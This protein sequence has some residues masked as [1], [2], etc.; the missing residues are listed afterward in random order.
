MSAR[1]IAVI[2][3]G[4]GCRPQID[5]DTG[6]RQS[7]IDA[8]E[9]QAVL[10][11]DGSLSVSETVTFA[12]DDG[13]TIELPG[14]VDAAGGTPTVTSPT[15]D[16]APVAVESGTFADPQL[17]IAKKQ[18]VVAFALT[19][20]VT[21]YSDIAV[22]D[23]TVLASPDGASRNDPDVRVTGTI[24]LPAPVDA[25]SVDA[26][27]Y[28]GREREIAVQATTVTFSSRAPVWTD[29]EV[30]L[31]IPEGLVPFVPAT[32]IPWADNFR[33]QA[34]TRESAARLTER[35]LRGVEL[36]LDAAEWL[37]FGLAVGIPGIFWVR[38]LLHAVAV[39]IRRRREVA[40]VP[41]HV[42]EPP[43]ADDPAVVSVLVGE[44]KPEKE[45]VAGTMLKLAQRKAI[46]IDEYGPD[47][48]VVKVPLT[49]MGTNGT[50]RIVLAALRSE[51]SDEG[52]IEGP[53]V[54]RKGAPWWRGYKRDAIH[55]AAGSGYVTRVLRLLDV[56]GALTTTAVGFCI[57]FFTRPWVF[58][59]ALP[60]AIVLS[61]VAS[62][63]AGWALTD[64]GRR[65]RALWRSFGRYI[66][67][68]GEL[69]NVGPAGV[70]IWGPYITYG[71]VLDEADDTA[72]VLSP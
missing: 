49:E 10:D 50:E 1:L 28:A 43:T 9:I 5:F 41:E 45:A 38:V 54:W 30:Q 24:T 55:A 27:N 71:V 21:R 64:K 2:V 60:A 33:A 57:Y 22:V 16:G 40:D 3:V 72:R 20:V 14:D 23:L 67:D 68:H 12:D 17:T 58:A 29:G 70:T 65:H 46:A 62:F 47:R 11:V 42:R 69:E 37:I 51:A 44:G 59:V 18:A 8:V 25:A 66:H 4:A 36:G 39:K 61:M 48:L 31:A 53:P 34:G 15:V 52:I 63:V 13:G 56:S 7:T 32:P 6:D 35:T 19:G 26:H